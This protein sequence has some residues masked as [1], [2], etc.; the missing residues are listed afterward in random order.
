MPVD[1]YKN[2]L[3][4]NF[5]SGDIVIALGSEERKSP[6]ELVFIPVEPGEIGRGYG[7]VVD[8]PAS[9]VNAVLRMRFDRVESLDVLIRAIAD[10]R[11][12][13]VAR[14]GESQKP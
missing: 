13:L 11:G 12:Y 7:E 10:L 5:G 4:L 2:T 9:E 1:I 6:S 3:I 14:G 8:K